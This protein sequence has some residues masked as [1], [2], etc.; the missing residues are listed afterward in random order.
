MI[1]RIK[2]LQR[3]TL[4]YLDKNLSQRQRELKNLLINLLAKVNYLTQK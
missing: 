2:G 4:I 3:D 1:K